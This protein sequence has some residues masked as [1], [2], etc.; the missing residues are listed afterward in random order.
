MV[1]RVLPMFVE[2]SRLID[3]LFCEYKGGFCV[4]VKCRVSGPVQFVRCI[5]CYLCHPAFAVFRIFEFGVE[6]NVVI[7]W[8]FGEIKVK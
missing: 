6:M 1:K 5:G 8:F 7:F 4:Y 2:N 3:G